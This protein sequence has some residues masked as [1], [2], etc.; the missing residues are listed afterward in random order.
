MTPNDVPIPPYLRRRPRDKRGYP[1]PFVVAR[2]PKSGAWLFAAIDP[3]AWQQVVHGHR[4]AICGRRFKNVFQRSEG[5]GVGEGVWFIGGGACYEN[6]YFLD[7]AMCEPCARYAIR[8]C[9]YLALS[10]YHRSLDTAFVERGLGKI[11]HASAP[12]KPD[13]FMLACTGGYS[14]R[15]VKGATGALETLVYAT[16]PWSVVEWWRDG[17][18][19]GPALEHEPPQ[20]HPGLCESEV[21]PYGEDG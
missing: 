3:R 11:V 15:T 5:I 20:E 4:C 6:R 13:R 17:K 16:L 12:G 1:V 2:D 19:V 8:V 7:P 21:F 14:V 10:S 18:Q 9:P